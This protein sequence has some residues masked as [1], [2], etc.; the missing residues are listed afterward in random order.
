MR[1]GV[2][3]GADERRGRDLETHTTQDKYNGMGERG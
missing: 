1:R 3:W 2:K